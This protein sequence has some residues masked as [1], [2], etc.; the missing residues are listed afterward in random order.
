MNTGTT[1]HSAMGCGIINMYADWKR[2][3]EKDNKMRLRQLDVSEL[4]L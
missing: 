4:D 3:W 1:L 2:M